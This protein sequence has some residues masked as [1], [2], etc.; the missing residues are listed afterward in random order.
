MD[1]LTGSA[2]IRAD[3]LLAALEDAANLTF[4]SIRAAFNE[5][6]RFPPPDAAEGMASLTEA[7]SEASEFTCISIG[8]DGEVQG[9]II[10]R[11][12]AALA[13]D[14]A[15]ALLMMEPEEELTETD[16]HDSL[17]EF[18]NI[19]GGVM[20]T[21]VLDPHGEYTLGLPQVMTLSSEARGE[22]AGSLLYTQARGQLLLEVWVGGDDGNRNDGSRGA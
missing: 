16:V 4:E 11:S 12:G 19:I 7:E 5:A 10:L 13:T 20:K 14:L 1:N 3:D 22:R 8:F 18:A 6:D 21:N 9:D 2:Q 15:R 17:A